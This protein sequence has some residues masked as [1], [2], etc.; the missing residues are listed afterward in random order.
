MVRFRAVIPDRKPRDE[1]Y[2]R[3]FND[4]VEAAANVA[5]RFKVPHGPLQAMTEAGRLV[6]RGIRK[7]IRA[8]KVQQ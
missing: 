2:T 1:E 5:A 7:N 8:L 4:A 3:G 6:Q